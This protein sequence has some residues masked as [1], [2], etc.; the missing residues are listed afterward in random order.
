MDVLNLFGGAS[1]FKEEKRVFIRVLVL[2]IQK[3]TYII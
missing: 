1:L 2:K 3:L